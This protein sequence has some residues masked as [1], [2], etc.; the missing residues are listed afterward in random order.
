MASSKP[1]QPQPQ[2]SGDPL[3]TDSCWNPINSYPSPPLSTAPP[4]TCSH[5]VPFLCMAFEATPPPS[6][7][8]KFR[9]S[10]T[11]P[12][13]VSPSEP[14]N[15]RKIPIHWVPSSPLSSSASH[16]LDVSRKHLAVLLLNEGRGAGYL[17]VQQFYF[18]H[19]VLSYFHDHILS[20]Y[21]IGAPALH[22]GL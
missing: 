19:S 11:Q 20:M 15:L 6:H 7:W 21:S 18:I 22:S 5:D 14:L 3:H 2:L 17:K 10:Q 9:F 12:N 13:C 1:Q 16:K 8:W 4:K